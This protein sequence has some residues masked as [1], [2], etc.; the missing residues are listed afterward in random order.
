MEDIENSIKEN[1]QKLE[2]LESEMKRVEVDATNVLA[3]LTK[4]KVK[5]TL[6]FFPS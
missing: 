4:A 5:Q 6:N 2:T 1:K 3:E